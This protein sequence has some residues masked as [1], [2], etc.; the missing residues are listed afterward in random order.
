MERL[1]N[2]DST[3]RNSLVSPLLRLPP[4][5]RQRIFKFALGGKRI[6]IDNPVPQFSPFGELLPIRSVVGTVSAPWDSPHRQ[7]VVSVD[8]RLLRVSRQIYSESALM[9]YLYNCFDFTQ[10]LDPWMMPS[11]AFMFWYGNLRAAQAYRVACIVVNMGII[12][13]IKSPELGSTALSSM[14]PNL[15]RLVVR[16]FSSSCRDT[17]GGVEKVND[18]K[19]AGIAEKVKKGERSGLRVGIVLVMDRHIDVNHVRGQT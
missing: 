6:R 16:I 15:G 17:I 5:L 2:L 4:T 3:R 14:F 7:L 11:T 12:A 1:T 8:V 13:D 18:E 9:P 19:T 10:L